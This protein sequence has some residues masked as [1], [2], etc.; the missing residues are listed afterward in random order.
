MR[1]FV[2]KDGTMTML[3]FYYP[4]FTVAKDFA[5]ALGVGESTVSG[6]RKAGEYPEY[7]RA[8]I[9]ALDRAVDAEADAEVA[10]REVET[11]REAWRLIHR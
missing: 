11:L 5:E 7:A 6:W 4:H 9:R 1:D 3:E 8:L 2:G 10:R